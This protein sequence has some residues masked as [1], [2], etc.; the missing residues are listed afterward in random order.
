[1]LIA[2][3]LLLTA[4]HCIAAGGSTNVICGQSKFGAPVAGG[5]TVVTDDV[6]PRAASL[7]YHGADVRVPSD[8][9]DTCGFDVALIILDRSVPAAQ[10]TPAV[11]R[12]DHEVVAGEPY[13]AIGYG[14]DDQGE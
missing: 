1:T 7:F 12:I 2:P 6:T 14:V 9:D 10:A 11:P 4:R 5:A 13:T 8:G 3:N